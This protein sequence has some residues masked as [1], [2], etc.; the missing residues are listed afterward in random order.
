ML[1]AVTACAGASGDDGSADTGDVTTSSST[2]LDPT[3]TSTS[4][5][6]T[7]TTTTT[8]TSDAESSTGAVIDGYPC[9]VQVVTHGALYDPLIRGDGPGV[10]PPIV[11]DTIEDACGCHTLTGGAQNLEWPGLQ[12]PGGTLFVDYAHLMNGFEATTLGAAI[13]A[14]VRGFR[15]PPGSCPK[16]PELAEILIPW[17]DQGMPDGATFVP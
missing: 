2:S 16:P 9:S 13:E 11:A 15:M 4:T 5:S 1:H 10:F 6:T 17:L 12:A 3:T 14:E 8:T 7:T